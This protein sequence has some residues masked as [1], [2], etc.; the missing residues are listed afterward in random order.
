MPRTMAP[1]EVTAIRC[2]ERRRIRAG[3]CSAQS[4]IPGPPWPLLT[5]FTKALVAGGPR[6]PEWERLDHPT[7]H[8]QAGRRKHASPLPVKL[9][10]A[11]TS[12]ME[13]HGRWP[14]RWSF[15]TRH[16]HPASRSVPFG[17]IRAS[18]M[19]MGAFLFGLAGLCSICVVW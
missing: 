16:R 11:T 1:I 18:H 5:G 12:R 6:P 4:E 17:T 8:L 19:G 10:V 2:A 14:A 3:F 13:K 7:L 15:S 9:R